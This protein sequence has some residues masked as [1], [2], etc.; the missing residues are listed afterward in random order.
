MINATE[1][2]LTETGELTEVLVN[3]PQIQ[4]FVTTMSLEYISSRYPSLVLLSN[5]YNIPIIRI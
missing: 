5:Q 2:A 1:N 4:A 3:Q